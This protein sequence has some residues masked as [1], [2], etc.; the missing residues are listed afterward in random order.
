MAPSVPTFSPSQLLTFCHLFI[1]SITN[2]YSFKSAFRNPQSAIET[3]CHPS[4]VL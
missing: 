3:L 2:S 1:A 4:S